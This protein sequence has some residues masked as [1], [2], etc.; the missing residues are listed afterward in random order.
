MVEAQQASPVHQHREK[1]QLFTS[2]AFLA[3]LQ[4]IKRDLSKLEL[5]IKLI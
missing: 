4:H 2:A 5:D 3:A 1:Q